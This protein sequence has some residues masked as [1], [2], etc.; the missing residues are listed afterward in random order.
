[1]TA[2]HAMIDAATLHRKMKLHS[3]KREDFRE[4][5]SAKT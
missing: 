5:V 1:M 3:L 4:R 2:E